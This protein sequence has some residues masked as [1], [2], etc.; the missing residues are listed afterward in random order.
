MILLWSESREDLNVCM[1]KSWYTNHDSMYEKERCFLPM[2]KSCF[3]IPHVMKTLWRKKLRNCSTVVDELEKDDDLE[4]FFDAHNN[5][6][7]MEEDVTL[8]TLLDIE[9]LLERVC[10][11]LMK[12]CLALRGEMLSVLED[13]LVLVNCNLH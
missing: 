6:E 12:K 11:P 9:I 5:L 4:G 8:L 2:M 10:R 1:K 13:M 7:P 3:L